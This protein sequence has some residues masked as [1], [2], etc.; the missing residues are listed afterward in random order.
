MERNHRHI[1]EVVRALRFQEL[2]IEFLGECVLAAVYLINRMPTSVLQGQS[3]YNIFH[4]R[5]PHLDHLRTIGYLCYDTRSMK[6]DKFSPRADAC[7][8]MGYSLTHKGYLLYDMRMKKFLV[9]RDVIFK[10]H[11]FP[12]NHMQDHHVLVFPAESF[13]ESDD[14][15]V[16]LLS[17]DEKVDIDIPVQD[18][19]GNEL[20]HDINQEVVD[21]HEQTIHIN[22]Y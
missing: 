7:V 12:F 9:C 13:I 10:G 20:S 14:T 5:K 1:L 8:M 21:Y 6:D 16:R 17:T 19:R 11:I 18:G 15:L 22:P 2:T 4:K 3:H